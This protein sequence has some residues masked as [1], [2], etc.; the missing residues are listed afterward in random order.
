MAGNLTLSREFDILWSSTAPD[1]MPMLFDNITARIPLIHWFAEQGRIE[2]RSGGFALEK[3]IYKERLTATGFSGLTN[4]TA[5]VPD[6]WTRIAYN[7]KNIAIP[8]KIPGT[9][10]LKNSGQAKVFDLIEGLLEAAELSGTEAIGGSTLG[11]FSTADETDETRIT[12]LQSVLSATQTTSGTVGQLNRSNAFWRQQ[13]GTAITDFSAHGLSRWRNLWLNC[14]RG[15]ETPGMVCT[16]LTQFSNF[17]DALTQSLS[18]NLPV[19]ASAQRLDVGFPDVFFLG[20]KVIHDAGVPASTA[21][22]IN[23]QTAKLIVHE[24][25]NLVAEEFQ[26]NLINGEYAVVSALIFSGNLA[27]TELTRNGVITGGDSD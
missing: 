4:I 21:Y 20:S 15:N 10:L 8:F 17:L 26:S 7:W 16:T 6:P 11:V 23:G 3:L 14:Q 13:V 22:M 24:D 19:V 1:V 5:T 2:M 18:Y 27:F 9:H 25:A 12:G